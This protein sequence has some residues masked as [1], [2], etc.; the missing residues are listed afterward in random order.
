MAG[1]IPIRYRD[2]YDVPRAV[3][4]EFRGKLYLFD[5]LFDFNERIIDFR[6]IEG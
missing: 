3:V 5:S 6:S 2:F 4:V 1:W